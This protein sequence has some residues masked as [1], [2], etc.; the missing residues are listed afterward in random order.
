MWIDRS[1]LKQEPKAGSLNRSRPCVYSNAVIQM[2]LC[3]QTGVSPAV[4]RPSAFCPQRSQLAFTNL[5]VP[6]YDATLSRRAQEIA[7]RGAHN[8]RLHRVR[9][10]DA[11]AGEQVRR[12]LAQQG[13]S[14]ASQHGMIEREYYGHHHFYE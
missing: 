3:T 9:E 6:N 4:A 11:P 1:V 5:P 12:G 13:P 14:V 2:L 10:R 8:H 7:A